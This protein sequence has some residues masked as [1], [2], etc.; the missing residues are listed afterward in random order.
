MTH[1]PFLS[2]DMLVRLH[3]VLSL[4]LFFPMVNPCIIFPPNETTCK[5]EVS[6]LLSTESTKNKYIVSRWCSIASDLV[7]VFV[8]SAKE[9]E[10]NE[11][12]SRSD[13]YRFALCRELLVFDA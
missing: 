13:A 9:E 1:D 10:G 2:V 11:K 12:R 5:S 8:C 4:P 6:L 7:D 3:K